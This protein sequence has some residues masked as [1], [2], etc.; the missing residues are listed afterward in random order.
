MGSGG[1]AG[2]LAGVACLVAS[3]ILDCC[4]GELARLRHAE[5][6][7]GHVLDVAGDTLVAVALLAGIVRRLVRSGPV[8]GWPVLGALALGVAGAFAAITWSEVTE[9][10]RHRVAR[11]ENRVLDGVLGPLT[12]RDWYVFPVAFA[13]AGRLGWLV[14]AA[15]VGAHVFWIVTL[16][17]LAARA[18]RRSAPGQRAAGSPVALGRLGER[19]Q[20]LAH[21]IRRGRSGCRGVRRELRDRRRARERD[22]DE[23]M[24][25]DEGDGEPVD[26]HSGRGRVQPGEQHVV[27]GPVVRVGEP[28]VGVHLLHDH[29]QA[30]VVCRREP[31]TQRRLEDV[32]GR[33]DDVEDTLAVDARRERQLECAR[34]RRTAQRD[35]DGTEGGTPPRLDERDEQRGV[36]ERPRLHRR[37]VDLVQ[38][39]PVAEKRARLR[40]L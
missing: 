15:A 21:A 36:A 16:V 4:D 37:A 39:H 11:W 10:R 32:E 9:S 34:R 8:P 22:V 14:P 23:W 2:V 1:A 40:E 38:V 25:Q 17:L 12:T 13:L 24:R 6:G 7:L 33:L 5:S 26:R 20:P 28:A 35:P 30:L 19:G 27:L 3:G 29:A 31:R 18:A